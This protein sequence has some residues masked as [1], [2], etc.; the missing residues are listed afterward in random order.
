MNGSWKYRPPMLSPRFAHEVA[1][2][3]QDVFVFGGTDG[4][5]GY[6]SVETRRTTGGGEWHYVSPMPGPRGNFAVGVVDGLVYTA[7]G[8]G[9]G[10]QSVDAVE[11]YDPVADKWVPGPALPV[12][13]ASAGGAG[14]GGKFYVAGGFVGDADADEHA[15][16]A[17]YVLDPADPRP[18]WV[19]IAPMLTP[20]AR[21]RLVAAGEH[22]YAIGGLPSRLQDALAS[23]ERYC[24]G[25]DTW[26]A[27]H[28]MHK[29][30]GL[31]GA[32]VLETE[33]RTRIAVVGGG[34]APGQDPIARDRTTEVLDVATGEWVLLGTLLPHGRASLVCSVTSAH[35]VLAIGGS[36]NL[37]GQR[38]TVPDVLSLKIF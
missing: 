28:P 8:I 18:H 12:P 20:R 7:G 10:D 11:I 30:R 14:L 36:A 5:V 23:A 33:G 13:L 2:V 6:S 35:R 1:T 25:T 4:N 19:P 22:L 15:T 3:G 17:V 37:Y 38:V 34:P 21:F 16:D 26:E 24:P 31:P 29:R 27:V 32:A 9:A